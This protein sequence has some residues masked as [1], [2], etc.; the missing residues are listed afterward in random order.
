[1][2]IIQKISSSIYH[3]VGRIRQ[4]RINNLLL[5]QQS[6]VHNQHT[7]KFFTPNSLTTYRAKTFA[8]KEPETLE[9]VDSFEPNAIMW[10]I[11]ANI[12][13]YSIYAAKTKNTSVFAFEPSVFNLEFLAKNIHVNK[14]VD[15]V[16]IIP[17]A[18]S[19]Q[20]GFS[21]FKMHNP[22]WGGALSTFGENFDQ[23]GN[24]FNTTFSYQ[25]PG[26]TADDVVSKLGVDVPNYIKIDVDGIEHLI[27]SG[28]GTTLRSVCSVL[29]EINDDFSEQKVQSEQY[30]LDAGLVLKHKFSLGVG[31]MHNQLWVRG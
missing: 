7:F 8:T 10:D 24:A 14:V 3:R 30:L 23:N 27:L 17:I 22:V 5:K 25:I 29:V 1:M 31:N 19:S 15:R 2:N 16:V 18:L 26:I 9:W 6:V 12:G 13:L 20:L 11:G 21:Q 28:L 4:K